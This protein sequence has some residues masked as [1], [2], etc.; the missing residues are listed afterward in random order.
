MVPTCWFLIF[1]LAWCLPLTPAAEEQGE[2]CE[3]KRCGNLTVSAPFGIVAGSEE[4]RCAQLGFQVHCFA[5]IPYLGYY[6][7]GYGL[8]ILDIFYANAS[9]LVSDVHK[10]VHFSNRSGG[11][12]S[13]P[14]ANTA[15]KVG[16]PF[17]ISSSNW[18]LVF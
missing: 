5:D 3:P 17:S 1:V 9:L 7:P 13:I 4:S 18:N 10:L 6:Q 14:V 11:V 16:A 12:C 2:A 8:Q 15:S